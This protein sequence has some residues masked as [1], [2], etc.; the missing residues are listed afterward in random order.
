MVAED[1]FYWQPE[2]SDI[3]LKQVAFY[4]Q[5]DVAEQ[6]QFQR[7]CFAFLQTTRIE[8]SGEL[9]ITDLDRLLIAAS[10]VMP[11][12][13]FPDWPYLQV[14][15]VVLFAGLFNRDFICGQADS[16]IA[17]MVGSGR[18][19]GKMA[20]SQLA[21][22]QGFAIGND[23]KNVALHE[24]AHL[25][26]MADGRCDGLPEVSIAEK[27]TTDSTTNSAA[28]LTTSAVISASMAGSR[29]WFEL[30]REKTADIEQRKSNIDEYATTNDQEFFAVAS[31]Y[32]F[33]R[34]VMLEQK[35]PR[36][37]RYLSEFY[38]QNLADIE[39]Q[40]K[41]MSRLKQQ[42]LCPCNSG[43]AFKHCCAR[44]KADKRRR[45]G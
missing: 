16:T 36:L 22:R 26:D 38:R 45:A 5:L 8:A 42:K 30:I 43:V 13:G 23:K 39:R 3:L 10:A 17:G 37:Y 29:P 35:H 21:L 7:C 12:W 28:N 25:F 32:F 4:R 15:C 18:M 41:G 44:Q 2:W 6:E 34:P 9:E 19:Q 40:H 27:P 33:E 1:E 31:E 11:V 24:F 14:N 20:L